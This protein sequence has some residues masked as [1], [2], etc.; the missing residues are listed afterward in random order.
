[1]IKCEIDGKEFSNGGVMAR[2]LKKNYQLTYKEYHHKYILKTDVVPTCKCGCGDE[3]RFKSGG[4]TEYSKGHYSRVHNNWGHN[5]SAIDKSSE[6][7]RQQYKNGERKVW[8]DGLTKETDERVRKNGEAS[9]NGILNNPT[10]RKHRSEKMKLQWETKNL[11]PLT[12]K[13]HPQWAGG[14]ST[15][16][17]LARSNNRLYKEWKKPIMKRDGFRCQTCGELGDLHVHHDGL[18]FS[19]II[20]IVFKD[21]ELLVE[22]E[23]F[24]SKTKLS[25]LVVDYHIENNV[26]GVTLCHDCHVELHPSLNF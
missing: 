12:G 6:T 13:D 9:S 19:E 14:S 8:N 22:S 18:T 1:M 21:N 26:S 11:I 10:E 25:D 4:Y 15:I 16:Q 17:Q 3:M 24:E 5:Q 23:E 7:R 2:Y 20:Q